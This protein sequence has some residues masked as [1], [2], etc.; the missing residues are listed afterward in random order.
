[1]N[2]LEQYLAAVEADLVG[3]ACGP[4]ER[5]EKARPSDRYLTGILFPEQTEELS[6]ET[7][8]EEDDDRDEATDDDL[9]LD[10]PVAMNAMR[11]PASMGISFCIRGNRIRLEA[12]AARYVRRWL[13]AGQVVREDQG[14]S[15]E[16]WIREPLSF[17][18]DLKLQEGLSQVDAIT[19]LCWWVRVLGL[20]SGVHQ[21]TVVLQNTHE[22]VEGRAEMEE[23]SF[24]QTRFE[25]RAGPGAE[26]LPRHPS[27]RW[28][29]EDGR[30]SA[31]IY[32]KMEEWAVGHTC[33]A[34]WGEDGRGRFVA[35][36]WLPRQHVPSTSAD[37]HELFAQVST[38]F[39]GSPRGAF[40]A[41][42]L[43]SADPKRLQVLLSVVPRAYREWIQ[44][45]RERLGELSPE[46]KTQAQVHLTRAEEIAGRI[47]AGIACL[48][49][50]DNARRA[51]QLAHRAML[52]QRR[53]GSSN[54]KLALEWRPF[55]LAFQL[56]GIPGLVHPAA[57]DG[58]PS[59]ERQI[60]DLLWFPTGGGKTEAYLG[61][62]AFLLLF[63]RLREGDE[64]DRGA[65]VAAIMRYTLRLLTV[66]QF[67][68]ASRMV[69]AC[70][71]L[72][73]EAHR[74]GDA[75]LGE[76][77]F[78]IGLW[79]GGDATPNL[80]QT[81]RESEYEAR[82]ARQLTRCP[83][84]QEPGLVWDALRQ[85]DYIVECRA[86]GCPLSGAPLPVH[87]IDEVVYQQSPSLLIGTVDKFAQIV[88]KQQTMQLFNAASIP[89][90]LIL[91]DEL[92]LISGPLGTVVGLYE[93]AID[94][95][96]SRDGIPPKV[97]G[98]TATIRRAED[99]V[100][101][102]FNREVSQFPPPAIDWDD[103][104]FA[105]RDTKAAGRLYV[106]AT[107]AGR[108]PK[109]T[110]QAV[111]AA[112]LQ[113]AAP[114][115][116]IF[117]TDAERDPYWTLLA[118]FNSMRE[119]G[120]AHVMM[121]DDVNDSM[122]VYSRSHGCN[123]R[124]RIEEP[125]ELT[126]RVPSSEIPD[127]L[128]RLEKSLPRQD[129][130]VVLA[131]NMISV[132]V[133]IPRLGLMVINGQ[134]KS[135]AEYIQASSRVG[136]GDIPGLIVTVYNAGRARDR[137]HY[138]SFRT[139]HQSLYREVEATSVTPF[140]PRARDKALH[141]ALVALARHLV[142]GMGNDA[143]LTDE[144]RV[145]LEPYAQALYERAEACDPYEAEETWEHLV[146]LLDMWEGRGPLGDYWNDY[147]PAQSLL[148]SAEKVAEVRATSGNWN[149]AALA[150][151][152]SM[153]EV[154]PS[155]RFR[156]VS[157][158]ARTPTGNEDANT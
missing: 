126:S 17:F 78:S 143:E 123:T 69:L 65:G 46:E 4:D 21:V 158:L 98:S 36:T 54:L 108:S 74:R 64:P 113:R 28:L 142:P 152:N 85:G 89:P 125:L 132:G 44:K 25:A 100:R 122:T 105:V 42:A 45:Q 84:C 14:R 136:R 154:E 130:S 149:H 115:E 131:T 43:A 114:E 48:N 41:E 13:L 72:R 50:D 133:D 16:C 128:A 6:E 101:G 3:P 151:P 134:P 67:E 56:L 109:F 8:A 57:E 144:R 63:R 157:G 29:D 119:L 71:H 147:K 106:G 138:E 40:Q 33:S 58:S 10:I 93:A 52:I 110:L 153:R 94:Q 15:K 9:G 53:W 30:A 68:R 127:T 20:G 116:G 32:R 97:V 26:L 104:C 91:Q 107:T 76:T 117:P 90:E 103:S 156:L 145:E 23:M 141:A 12:N 155:V 47:E 49:E 66:Q 38:E 95:I 139:W 75:S 102:L 34:T 61:L 70:E 118:Y 82:K 87:T 39:T 73:R 11:R 137:A 81:A 111:C 5:L 35:A 88:R 18:R 146:T 86:D 37:G 99:Q 129:V 7:S 19:G 96:C 80:I 24:F 148:V 124:E 1:M 121:L 31:L 77:P 92:H 150:T 51:F 60:M 62:I 22:S 55:Q 83:A 59:R 140:A 120:G 112:L 27:R 135:M 79:V 2:H